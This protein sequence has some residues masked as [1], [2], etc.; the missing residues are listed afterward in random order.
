[1]YKDH[2]CCCDNKGYIPAFSLQVLGVMPKLQ[3]MYV[4]VYINSVTQLFYVACQDGDL[5]LIG[6]STQQGRVEICFDNTY[7][8]ICRGLW[9]EP[10]AQVVCRQLGFS[11]DGASALDVPDDGSSGPVYLNNV[12]CEGDEMN[13][14]ECDFDS[15]VLTCDQHQYAGVSCNGK[16]VYEYMIISLRITLLPNFCRVLFFNF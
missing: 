8:L 1:M 11:T 12:Q 4:N 6:N 13:I 3:Y 7:G 5:R 16:H 14:T 2:K 10:D 15:N 9:N